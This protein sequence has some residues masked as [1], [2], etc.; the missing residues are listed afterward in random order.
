MKFSGF[1]LEAEIPRG[2]A[3]AVRRKPVP[4]GPGGKIMGGEMLEL[5]AQGKAFTFVTEPYGRGLSADDIS[6]FLAALTVK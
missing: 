6:R 4:L 1:A 3:S 2:T 5:T